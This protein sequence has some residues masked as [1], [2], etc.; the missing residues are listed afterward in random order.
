MTEQGRSR[1]RKLRSRS[2][3]V[4]VSGAR[5]QL[6]DASG[7][8]PVRELVVEMVAESR[9]AQGLPR[10]IE[11]APTLERI[12][13]LLSD[14]PGAFIEDDSSG[15]EPISRADACRSDGD[16]IEDGR[17]DRPAAVQ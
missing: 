14:E 7:Q 9:E 13:L 8:I 3:A 2:A 4:G 11:H 6:A 12:A 5:P 15:V 1:I 16:V 17:D 10:Y